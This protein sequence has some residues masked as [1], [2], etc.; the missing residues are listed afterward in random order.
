MDQKALEDGCKCTT[1]EDLKT[2]VVADTFLVTIVTALYPLRKKIN[3]AGIER[4]DII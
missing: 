2:Q 3:G 4:S 1:W